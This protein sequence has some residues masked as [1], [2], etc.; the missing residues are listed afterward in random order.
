MNLSKVYAYAIEGIVDKIRQQMEQMYRIN[1]TVDDLGEMIELVKDL[2][3]AIKSQGYY[4]KYE[5]GEQ[6]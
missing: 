5:N 6:P 3:D 2:D 1:I 4:A